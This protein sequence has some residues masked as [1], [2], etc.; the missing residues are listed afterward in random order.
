MSNRVEIEGTNMADS[1]TSNGTYGR[2]CT[3]QNPS[4]IPPTQY[5]SQ[6]PTLE[7]ERR[8][9]EEQRRVWNDLAINVAGPVF[10]FLPATGRLLGANEDQVESLAILNMEIGSAYDAHL[11]APK[12]TNPSAGT[13][14]SPRPGIYAP[15]SANTGFPYSIKK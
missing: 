6:G 8:R 10:G 14:I 3:M 11:N 7:E 12:S 4:G 9:A 1:Y 2:V 5:L 15:P 13:V